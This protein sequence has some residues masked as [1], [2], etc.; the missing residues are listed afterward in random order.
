[1]TLLN[2]VL[3]CTLVVLSSSLLIKNPQSLQQRTVT[4]NTI[5]HNALTN[6]IMVANALAANALSSNQLAANGVSF[7]ALASNALT[8]NALTGMATSDTDN[9]L[10]VL[11]S[12]S[13]L[14][15]AASMEHVTPNLTL[16][17]VPELLEFFV[18]CALNEGDTWNV[19]YNGT[20]YTF[21]GSLGLAPSIVTSPPTY[22][23]EL[24]L[25]SCLMVRVNHFGRHVLIS[26][27]GNAFTT[28]EEEEEEYT[29]FE[30]SFFGNLFLNPQ[31]KYACQ[32]V[33]ESIA[34]QESPDR[35]WR[36]CTD[37]TVDCDFTVVGMCSDV[38]LSQE[39]PCV[40][41]GTE[42]SDVINSYLRGSSGMMTRA[43]VAVVVFLVV[44]GLLCV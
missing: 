27:R 13:L 37:A 29:V 30:G 12:M 15:L 9:S 2:I 38:C 24:W 43:N 16:A 22:Q 20:F 1:M 42:W 21:M 40:A 10:S 18:G 35:Q 25:S 6:N 5:T 41:N 11:T 33:Q 14:E 28:T 34:I 17:I 36:V 26:L 39:G 44:L 32:G 23:Q 4:G 8:F 31:Q 3:L 19:T 7:N